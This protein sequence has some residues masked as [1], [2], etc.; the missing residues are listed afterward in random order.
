MSPDGVALALGMDAAGVLRR[1]GHLEAAGVIAR[2]ADGRY[3]A[4]RR[5]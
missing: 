3:G 5:R 2:Y 1:I 4:G